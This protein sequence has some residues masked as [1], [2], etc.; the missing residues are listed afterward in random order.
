MLS[1]DHLGDHSFQKLCLLYMFENISPSFETSFMSFSVAMWS[2]RLKRAIN[3]YKVKRIES[4]K[5]VPR[6]LSF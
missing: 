2:P 6:S 3:N 4:S 5:M 1:M